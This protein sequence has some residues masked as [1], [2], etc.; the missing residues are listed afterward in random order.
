M[1]QTATI[2]TNSTR[3]NIAG[4]PDNNLFLGAN[5][6]NRQGNDKLVARI[7]ELN[8]YNAM[9]LAKYYRLND[10]ANGRY[11][12]R[13]FNTDDMTDVT[14]N[15]QWTDPPGL[16]R[17]FYLWDSFFDLSQGGYAVPKDLMT[18]ETWNAGGQ[19]ASGLQ[20]Y[21]NGFC[22]WERIKGVATHEAPWAINP[23]LYDTIYDG[24]TSAG[25]ITNDRFR[26]R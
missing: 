13:V 15:N 3:V 14:K 12:M 4:N 7:R 2:G 17:E 25:W 16:T 10:G 23:P 26:L 18:A 1:I 24:D 5:L 6:N 21:N 19:R 9:S 8:V 11:I 22:V 20:I